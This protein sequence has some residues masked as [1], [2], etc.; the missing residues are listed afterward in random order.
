M[1]IWNS[2]LRKHLIRSKSSSYVIYFFWVQ[3]ENLLLDASGNLKVSDFGLS[4]LSQQIKV[5]V[6]SC[7][8]KL[9]QS[10]LSQ[11]SILVK[12]Y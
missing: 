9:C 7:G 5:N 1:F 6:T 4:A 2:E 10:I 3:P 11:F 12:S 8:R